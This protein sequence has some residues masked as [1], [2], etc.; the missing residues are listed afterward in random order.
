MSDRKI[1]LIGVDGVRLDIALAP[2]LAPNLQRVFA[3]GC[4]QEMTM[5]VP[6]ISGPGWSSILT[7]TTHAQ[8][9]VVDNTFRGNRLAYCPTSCPRPPT[10]IHDARLMRR[11][12]GC[13]LSTQ[14][15]Q[16]R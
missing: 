4:M 1:C 13:L 10:G 5:E 12:A 3:Q 8:H 2:G 6:T 11:P 7:G 16:A 14:P 9:G 15:A